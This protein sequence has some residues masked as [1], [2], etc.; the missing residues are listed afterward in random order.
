[1]VDGMVRNLCVDR[2]IIIWNIFIVEV[3]IEVHLEICPVIN[4][5]DIDKNLDDRFTHVHIWTVVAPKSR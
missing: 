3:I 5:S 1:M 2:D 4:I